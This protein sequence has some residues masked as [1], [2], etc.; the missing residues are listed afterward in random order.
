MPRI[1]KKYV[2]IAALLLSLRNSRGHFVYRNKKMFLAL[3]ELLNAMAAHSLG[4][5]YIF[6]QELYTRYHPTSSIRNYESDREYSYENMFI[7]DASSGDISKALNNKDILCLGD[8]SSIEVIKKELIETYGQEEIINETKYK[9]CQLV[10]VFDSLP[11]ID[12]E[13]ILAKQYD[14]FVV[15]CETKQVLN[16]IFPENNKGKLKDLKWG[17]V[18]Y[19]KHLVEPVV[20]NYKKQYYFSVPGSGTTSILDL[21]FRGEV[22]A[23]MA[24]QTVPIIDYFR[25]IQ[26]STETQPCLLLGMYMLREKLGGFFILREDKDSVLFSS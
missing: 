3:P 11:T 13:S 14:G 16:L 10:Q 19:S 4:W 23:A 8:K 6:A 24:Y 9:E 22:S 1:V 25:C 18:F 26:P 15:P 12:S 5:M 20:L 2:F 17:K 7:E 21:K